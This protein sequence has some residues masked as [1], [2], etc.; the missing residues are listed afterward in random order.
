MDSV[1]HMLDLLEVSILLKILRMGLFD[2]EMK[3][4]TVLGKI[5]QNEFNDLT[6]AHSETL[7]GEILLE[8][9]DSS[10]EEEE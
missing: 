10:G 4:A 7:T 2:N 6:D 8:L 1:D 3:L 5:L 9:T